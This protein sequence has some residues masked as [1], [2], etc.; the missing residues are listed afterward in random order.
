M[1]E[2]VVGPLAIIIIVL[3]IAGGF[4]LATVISNYLVGLGS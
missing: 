1:C 3:G 4:T 2:K